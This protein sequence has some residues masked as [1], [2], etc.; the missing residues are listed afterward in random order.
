MTSTRRAIVQLFLAT[1]LV[2]SVLG[3]GYGCW[4]DYQ[5]QVALA[6]KAN[7]L[8]IRLSHYNQYLEK[9]A[10]GNAKYI[11]YVVNR[12]QNQGSDLV[13]LHQA[14]QITI[15]ADS[16]AELLAGMR[17]QIALTDAQPQSLQ[18]AERLDRYSTFIRQFVPEAHALTRTDRALATPSQFEHYYFQDIPE[19]LLLA[20]L[21]RLETEIRRDE[22]SALRLLSQKIGYGCDCFDKIGATAVPVSA[23]VA[24]G[25]IYQAQLLLT[26]S[27]SDFYYSQLSVNGKKIPA[28]GRGQWNIEI[29]IPPVPKDMPDTVRTKWHGTIRTELYP[30]DTTWHLTTP[31]FIVKSP[32]R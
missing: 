16:V 11:G 5:S 24:P 29:P 12:H 7:N 4:R 17:G 13:V 9:T 19:P 27:F 10:D 23:T 1:T 28:I 8:D 21:T 3:A 26:E 22:L 14:E 18:L 32:I 30:A 31:F 6:E 2:S 15:Q 25:A 20:V